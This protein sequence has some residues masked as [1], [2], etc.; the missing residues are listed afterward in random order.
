MNQEINW[1]RPSEFTIGEICCQ[2]FNDHLNKAQTADISFTQEHVNEAWS[3]AA[4]AVLVE[5]IRLQQPIPMS[6]F[7]SQEKVTEL[8]KNNDHRKDA[9]QPVVDELKAI[10]ALL[11]SQHTRSVASG[12]PE[13]TPHFHHRPKD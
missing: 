2:A 6:E 1:Q 7:I 13:I 4:N 5:I 10:R 8:E 12:S 3:V 9:L 11:E